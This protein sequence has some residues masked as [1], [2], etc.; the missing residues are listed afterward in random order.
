MI[1]K[2]YLL[3]LAGIVWSIAGYNVLH[4][5]LQAYMGHWSPVLFLGSAIVFLIFQFMIFGKLVKKHTRRIKGYQEAKKWFWNFFDL[6]SF[7][8]MAFM[9]TVGI[10][11]RNLNLCPEWFIAFFYTGLGASLF[12]AGISFFCQF[13]QVYKEAF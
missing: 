3:F 7:L 12:L 11:I 2:K 10:L 9:I 6:K 1:S 8:I 5:G 4:I 13:F